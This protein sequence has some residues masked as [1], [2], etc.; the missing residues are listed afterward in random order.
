MW[1][2]QITG[3]ASAA[4][5]SRIVP[6]IGHQAAADEGAVGQGIEKQQFAHGVAQQH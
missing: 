3:L 6:A 5:S 1:P 2:A 4:G